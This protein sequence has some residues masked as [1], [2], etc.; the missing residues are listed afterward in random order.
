MYR[1]AGQRVR[2]WRRE[3]HDMSQIELAARA[4]VSVGCIQGLETGLRVTRKANLLKIA[5][6]IGLSVDELTQDEEPALGRDP[7]LSQPGDEKLRAEDLAVARRFHDADTDTRLRVRRLLD[8]GIDPGLHLL[9]RIERL[10]QDFQAHVHTLVTQAETQLAEEHDAR[11][12][13][14]QF[15]RKHDP[16]QT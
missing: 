16:P 14:T 7:R 8:E 3:H 15:R 4:G 1:R 12:R 13:Q 11:H 10:D 9:E 6:V 2:Q 5:Q